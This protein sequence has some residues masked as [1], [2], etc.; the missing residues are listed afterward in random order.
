MMLCFLIIPFII[1]NTIKYKYFL[2]D[3]FK[4]SLLLNGRVVE[5][6]IL[7]EEIYIKKL[8]W[9]RKNKYWVNPAGQIIRSRQFLNPSIDYMEM[10]VIKKYDG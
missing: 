1:F 2:G 9:K 6:R 10:E 3:S 5:G 8:L 4:Y 7:Y